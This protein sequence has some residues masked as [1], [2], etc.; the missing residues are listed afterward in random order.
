MG[1]GG[2]GTSKLNCSWFVLSIELFHQVNPQDEHYYLLTVECSCTVVTAARSL[3]SLRCTVCVVSC[4][5]TTLGVWAVV[6]L[7][8]LVSLRPKARE[9]IVPCIT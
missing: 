5:F 8:L 7:A 1:K 3:Q 4:L 2:S 6:F 9:C